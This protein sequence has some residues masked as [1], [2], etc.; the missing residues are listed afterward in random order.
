MR[1]EYTPYPE[2]PMPATTETP[3]TVTHEIRN[4]WTGAVLF[5]AAVDASLTIGR[6]IG[7][8]VRLAIETDADLRRA[9]LR[10]A[11]LTGAA[12]TGA[13]LTDADLTGADLRRAALTGAALTGADLRG[14]ALTGADLTDA[15]LR[16]AALT[17]ADLTDADL[18][19]ADLTDAVLRRADLR[20]ADLTD[21]AL[22][23]ADLT[24]A[25]LTGAALTGAALTGA[26]LTGAVLTDAV[27]RRA[28]LRGAKIIKVIAR[29]VR[30]DG[31]EAIAFA[32]DKGVVIRMGC[33]TWFG[34]DAGRAHVATYA[35]RSDRSPELAAET[36]AI[37][38]FIDARSK[39]VGA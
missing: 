36:L 24:D 2:E 6:R 35:E 10:R 20:R 17:G 33:R 25:V 22:T 3:P 31:Y 15:D 27:L 13:D 12:L 9:D 19:G 5:A 26:A 30:S 16:R 39:Q 28:D 29:A 14:A 32:T 21:A 11:D 7:L 23:G 8:T 18:T 37:L 34:T 1:N 4:R 38:D